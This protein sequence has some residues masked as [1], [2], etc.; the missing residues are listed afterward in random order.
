MTQHRSAKTWERTRIQNLLRHKS[1]RYYARTFAGGKEVWKSLKTVHF[2]V[3][4][5]RLAEFLKER[6]QR[7]SN[8][9]GEVSAKMTF[10]QAAEIHLQNLDDDLSIK[11]RTRDYWRQRLTALI[12]SWPRLDET[13][14][15]KITQADCKKWASAYG[16]KVSPANYNNTVALF[17]HVLNVAVEAGVIYGNSAAMLKRVPLRG[18]HVS[19]P[20]AAKFIS[21]LAEMRAGHGRYSRDCA[22]FAEGLAFTG[23]RR[24]EAKEIEWR[25]VDFDASALVVRGDSA[26]GT[27]NWEVRRVPLIADAQALFRRMRSERPDDPLDAKVFRVREC[28]KSLDRACKKVGADRITHHDLRHLFA[29][30]CIESGVDVPTVS[31]WLGHKDGGALLMKTYGHLRDEHSHAQAKR[32]TF[33]VSEPDSGSKI[34]NF[35]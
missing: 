1:G 28:Q 9:N 13:E 12:K 27:K 18:K 23:C 7:A 22:D 8:G 15:R 17:R 14:I 24:G 10:R 3:A 35:A 11:P 31:R 6:R 26:T 2:E 25:D 30:R 32:V 20:T 5:A 34:V 33:G 29:T 21:M 19:L 16:K 4:Q